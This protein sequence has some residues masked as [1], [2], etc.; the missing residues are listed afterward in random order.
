MS[1]LFLHAGTQNR[2]R[3]NRRTRIILKIYEIFNQFFDAL[4]AHRAHG[5][6]QI[7]TVFFFSFYCC[8]VV[9]LLCMKPQA[10]VKHLQHLR[11]FDQVKYREYVEHLQHFDQVNTCS[12]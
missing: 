7:P 5:L 4:E 12:T 10:Y 1:R 3:L 2:M 6:L 9:F 8:I 11:H